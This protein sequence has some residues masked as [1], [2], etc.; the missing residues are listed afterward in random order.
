MR[1]VE[2]QLFRLNDTIEQLRRQIELVE[3]ELNMHR[4]LADDAERDAT[5]SEGTDR[6][7]SR[8]ANKDVAAFL[9]V[10]EQQ[11]ANIRFAAVKKLSELIQE[12]GLSP[13]I[14]PGLY[15]EEGAGDEEE[16][17]GR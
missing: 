3:G 15:G 13:D 6:A 4:H 5:V 2:R 12:E 10:K 16:K 9:S 17:S 14:F 7:E 8:M 1:R 11:V